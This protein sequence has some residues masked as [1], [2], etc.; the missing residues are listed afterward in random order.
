MAGTLCLAL[1]LLCQGEEVAAGLA[2][3]ARDV[4]ERTTRALATRPVD[5]ITPLLRHEN[6]R[7]AQG[8]ARALGLRGDPAGLPALMRCVDDPDL[9]RACAA[10]TASVRI[11]LRARVP[12]T[13]PDGR[14]RQRLQV[15]MDAFVR[16]S[17]GGLKEPGAYD[18]PQLYRPLL[19]GGEY[20]A[21]GLETLARDAAQPA[22]Q[23]VL[24]LRVHFRLTGDV[25]LPGELVSDP[26]PKVRACCAYLLWRDRG[27]VAVARLAALFENGRI[28]QPSVRAYAVA[29]IER[30]RKVSDRGAARLER[31]V[32]QDSIYFALGAAA[33]LARARPDSARVPIRTRVREYARRHRTEAALF[34]Y[35]VGPFD[36]EVEALFG[37]SRNDL[38]Q[39]TVS[40]DRPPGALL[41]RSTRS[42]VELDLLAK[43]AQRAEP[44]DRVAFAS[45]LLATES[46]LLRKTGLG[47]LRNLPREAYADVDRKLRPLLADPRESVRVGAAALLGNDKVAIIVLTEALYD[48]DPRIATVVARALGASRPGGPPI[49][50]AAPVAE[51]RTLA[52]ALVPRDKE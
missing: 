2:D 30:T 48:G 47:L 21:V 38:L 20:A 33:A 5:A 14:C 8:A 15:A 24:A 50:P 41:E 1:A 4:R 16:T 3:P 25:S 6:P 27:K 22:A 12:L 19:G 43:L 31:I 49:D 23:R 34:R 46:T 10:A 7:V 39:A 36:D 37:A 29:A 13:D 40:E 17:L 9:V 28:L 18:R 32:R 45:R 11:A 26:E 42:G 35:R 52:N 51:R 44:K